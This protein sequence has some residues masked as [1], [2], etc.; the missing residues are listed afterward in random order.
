MVT[1]SIDA[2]LQ[3]SSFVNKMLFHGKTNAI[4]VTV[5]K[6]ERDYLDAIKSVFGLVE[7]YRNR[8]I[9]VVFNALSMFSEAFS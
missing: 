3:S 7:V 5:D 6:Y 8:F 4:S 1:S 2:V 9:N